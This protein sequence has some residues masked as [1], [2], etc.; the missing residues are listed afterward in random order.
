MLAL[1]HFQCMAPALEA[2]ANAASLPPEF[3]SSCCG[4]PTSTTVPSS[5]TA[6]R[7]YDITALRSCAT[8]G[9]QAGLD[10]DVVVHSV[11]QGVYVT[12]GQVQAE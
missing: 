3:L 10:S 9:W 6:T 1:Q 2:A 7:S 4:C 8:C 12:P 5:I 11:P